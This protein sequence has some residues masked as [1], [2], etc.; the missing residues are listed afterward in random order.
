MRGMR[1]RADMIGARLRIDSVVGGGTRVT[2][3]R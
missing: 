1:E 2:V 3:E